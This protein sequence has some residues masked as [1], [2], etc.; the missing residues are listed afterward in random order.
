M[1]LHVNTSKG[2]QNRYS[3]RELFSRYLVRLSPFR[4]NIVLLAAFV[5]ISAIAEI[6]LPPLFGYTIDNLDHLNQASFEILLFIGVLYLLLS[7][8]IWIM[9]SLR[10]REIGRFIPFFLEKLRMDIFEKIQE[11]DM[12]FH[13]HHQS[14]NLNSRVSNDA[15]DFGDV[16]II[17]ADNIGNVILG[18]LTFIILF[19]LNQILAIITILAVPVR[20]PRAG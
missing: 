4:K 2:R 14:G 7:A 18:G 11:Q 20:G 17:I 15:L 9:F 5:I 1:G 12:S 13:D 16:S 6:I 19:Y 10:R 3:D 8:L